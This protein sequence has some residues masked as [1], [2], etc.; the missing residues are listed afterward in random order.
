MEP[1]VDPECLGH[2][3]E[4]T[5]LALND[6]RR[7]VHGSAFWKNAVF[8]NLVRTQAKGVWD[9]EDSLVT[10][11]PASATHS[12]CALKISGNGRL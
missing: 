12:W 11:L 7:D 4:V 2:G 3:R 10:D 6:V 5:G 9:K 8:F 1:A